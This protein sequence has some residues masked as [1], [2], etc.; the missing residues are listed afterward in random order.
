MFAKITVRNAGGGGNMSTWIDFTRISAVT[1][2]YQPDGR[3]HHVR[4]VTVNG[5][6]LNFGAAD[7]AADVL[8]AFEQHL[9]AR[10]T[11]T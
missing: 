11:A 4:V 1:A 3:L 2:Q 5:E 10:P 9:A 8:A 7:G 6:P